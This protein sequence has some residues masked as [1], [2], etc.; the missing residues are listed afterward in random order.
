MLGALR[1]RNYRL[2][3]TGQIISTIGTWMQSVAM[4]WLALQLTH[5][6]FLVGLVLAAQFTPVLLGSQFGGVV[7][8]RYR[9]RTVLLVTQSLFTIP[10]FALF[11]LSFT[12]RAQFWM[13]VVAAI[14]TGTINLFDV[15]SRQSFVIEMVG[16]Q[17]LMNAIALNS[18]VFNLAAVVGPAVAGLLIAAVGVPICFL[19]NSVSYLAAI[20]ALLLMRDLPAVVRHGA[21]QPI[22]ARIAEGASYARHEP[23]V[24]M[25]LVAVAV[26]SLFAMNRLTLIPFFADQ[27]LDVGAKGFGFL[28]GSMGLGALV[29]ALTLA[30]SPGASDPRRQFWMA[31]IWVAALLA[32]S[33]SRVFVISMVTLFIAGYCQITFVATANNRIQT[34]TPDHLRGR[35]M[36]FYAQALIGVGPIGS[37]QAGA[38]ATLFGAPWAMAIG[39]VVAGSVILAIRITRPY[40][41]TPVVEGHTPATPPAPPELQDV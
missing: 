41:F 38:L 9:K 27:V 6:P 15:P 23:V 17:D 22:F 2:F 20:V 11:L 36:A 1:H 13:I 21:E 29:G 37:M 30:L 24:G 28:L 26:F 32:F 35:V 10:S 25:L 31:M 40:V 18:S 16:R 3:L 12:G 34:I 39:A 14:A 7:A 8:D 33:I 5:N 19:A 4:P